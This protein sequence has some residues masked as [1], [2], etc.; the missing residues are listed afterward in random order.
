MVVT[1]SFD[2]RFQ[3]PPLV[4]RY[5]SSLFYMMTSHKALLKLLKS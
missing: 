3:S 4:H 5:K 2:W 1:E